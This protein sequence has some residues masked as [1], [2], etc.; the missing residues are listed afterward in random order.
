MWFF[1]LSVYFRY[2]WPV[3]VIR[4][5]VHL[6]KSAKLLSNPILALSSYF[7]DFL[8][9]FSTQCSHSLPPYNTRRFSGVF[10]WYKIRTFPANI[11]LFKVNNRN[12]STRCE[13]YSNLIIKTPG[14]RHWRRSDVFIVD[15]E[16]ISNKFQTLN[17]KC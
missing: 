6:T 5:N 11:Y 4:K 10:R 16:H 12:T 13:I 1:N 3:I 2:I 7:T 17:S 15:F 14:R 9:F 8:L